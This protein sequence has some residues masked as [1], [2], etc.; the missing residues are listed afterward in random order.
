MRLTPREIEI[1]NMI[2]GGLSGKE[3]AELLRISF[4]T[5]ERHRNDIRRKFKIVGKK[6]NLITFLQNI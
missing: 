1:C 4:K 2:K 5:V 6:V 3:I